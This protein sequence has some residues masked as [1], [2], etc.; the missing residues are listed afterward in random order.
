MLRTMLR[1]AQPADARKRQ[2]E[3]PFMRVLRRLRS[4]YEGKSITTSQLMA[5]FEAELPPSLW[6]EGH[7]SL[8]WFYDSWVNGSA[9]PRLELHNLKFTD[10][11]GATVVT[12]TI[13]QL[14]TPDNLVTAVPLYAS[15]GGKN[16]FAAHVFADGP[17]TPFRI[18]APAHTRK[19]LLDPD[20][21]LLSRK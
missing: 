17:E 6:Y 1:D 8:D 9:L 19:I 12:G 15:V 3:E 16:L 4:E 2:T 11:P 21:T 20:Q 14:E 7:K 10:K 13:V 18:S 5:L